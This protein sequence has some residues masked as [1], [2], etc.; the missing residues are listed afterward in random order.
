[1]ETLNDYRSRLDK[2]DR[3]L[4]ALFDERM[5]TV[6]GVA[7]YKQLHS[8]NTL[9]RSRELQVLD[10]VA[11]CVSPDCEPYVRRLYESIMALS[12]EYQTELAKRRNI[13][14]IGMPG[15]G[16]TTV[17]KALAEA[18]NMLFY[19][20]DEFIEE[21]NNISVPDYIRQNGEAAFRELE[22]AA[23]E[24]IGR[25][26]NAV[27]ATGGG[28]VKTDAAMQSLKQNAVIVWLKHPDITRLAT[29]DRPLS[30]DLA[31]LEKERTPLYEAYSDLTVLNI[32]SI[33]QTVK[34]ISE[35]V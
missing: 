12:R 15:C 28:T 1:M 31:R 8:L 17:G 3:Q 20:T 13:V 23:C 14:L 2:I 30:T 5:Q 10:K 7:A 35:H 26:G 21:T 11:A 22:Q 4:S 24:K 18:R 6:A 16:K 34:E 19:D 9:D 25:L 33:D 27:I 29:K 32:H